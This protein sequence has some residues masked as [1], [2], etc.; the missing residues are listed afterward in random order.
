MFF[1]NL[2][3][4]DFGLVIVEETVGLI[5]A[6]LSSAFE[7]TMFFRNETVFAEVNAKSAFLG[8]SL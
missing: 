6:Q 8:D 2:N 1:E 5:E 4:K 3:A 7:K